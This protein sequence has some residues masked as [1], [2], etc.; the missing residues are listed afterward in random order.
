MFFKW[1]ANATLAKIR[2][3]AGQRVR[4]AMQFAMRPARDQCGMRVAARDATSRRQ[5]TRKS[6]AVSLNRSR[7]G[8]ARPDALLRAAFRKQRLRRQRRSPDGAGYFELENRIEM[9]G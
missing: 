6:A 5:R 9:K 1:R 2:R 8:D 3:F 4:C 7:I